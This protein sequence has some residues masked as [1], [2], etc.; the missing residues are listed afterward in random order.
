MTFVNFGL[1]QF[2]RERERG[3]RGERKQENDKKRK[4]KDNQRRKN[5]SK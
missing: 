2:Q 5:E 4:V 1:D 3:P